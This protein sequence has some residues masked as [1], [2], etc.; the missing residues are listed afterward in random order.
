[1]KTFVSFVRYSEKKVNIRHIFA[2]HLH[3]NS[4]EVLKF[5][6]CYCNLALAMVKK[7][8]QNKR[9]T[10]PKAKKPPKQLIKYMQLGIKMLPRQTTVGCCH[11]SG[12]STSKASVFVVMSQFNIF[13]G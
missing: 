1:M 7:T 2:L 10:K 9:Q 11:G 5:I 12:G 6:K 8:K 13:D 3:Q 4:K